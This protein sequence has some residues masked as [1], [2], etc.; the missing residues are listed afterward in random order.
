MASVGAWMGGQ[1]RAHEAPPRAPFFAILALSGAEMGPK[2]AILEVK[3]ELNES[4][5][6]FKTHSK[7]NAKFNKIF[8]AFSNRC[9]WVVEC[10]HGT[11]IQW[12]RIANVSW[13]QK[14]GSLMLLLFAMKI[15]DLHGSEGLRI[16]K[17]TL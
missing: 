12:N 2:G 5:N 15:N 17:T 14:A 11:K 16:N 7:I 3:W 9:S 10:Q 1:R 13:R 6:R 4:Q 8:N